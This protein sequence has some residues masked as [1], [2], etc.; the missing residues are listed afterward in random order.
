MSVFRSTGNPGPSVLLENDQ[1]LRPT[2]RFDDGRVVR[3]IFRRERIALL[4]A[5]A[6]G[7]PVVTVVVTLRSRNWRMSPGIP[8]GGGRSLLPGRGSGFCRQRARVAVDRAYAARALGA[9]MHRIVRAPH[10]F[11]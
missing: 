8:R 3:G 7:H 4:A 6:I 9:S 11:D 1:P 10:E 5:V 2:V